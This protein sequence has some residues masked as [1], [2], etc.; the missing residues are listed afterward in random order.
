MALIIKGSLFILCLFCGLFVV[1]SFASLSGFKPS[2]NLDPLPHPFRSI[3]EIVQE[4]PLIRMFFSS[5]ER[6]LILSYGSSVKGKMATAVYAVTIPLLSVI[7]V[8]LVFIFVDVWY[9]ALAMCFYGVTI[10]YLAFANSI[11]AKAANVREAVIPSYEAVER[12]VS[13]NIQVIEATQNVEAGS[14][15]AVRQI[16]SNFNND[17]WTDKE[18]AYSNFCEVVGDRYAVS[19]M[20]ALYTYDSTGESPCELIRNICEIG[21]RDYLNKRRTATG[22]KNS[23]ILS[24]GLCGI[25]LLMGYMAKINSTQAVAPGGSLTYV[26]LIIS[27]TGLLLS[28]IYERRN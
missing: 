11:Q 23:K 18:K 2:S 1:Y 6:D 17:Y 8:M 15:G 3:Y 28:L 24:G 7:F 13:N 4:H 22:Y 5:L 19:F 16:Y 25:I 21:G 10:P 26:A 20:R 14:V 9:Y 27:L 12:Y